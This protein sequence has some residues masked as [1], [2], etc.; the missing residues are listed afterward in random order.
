MRRILFTAL[1]ALTLVAPSVNA[2]EN[3]Q[4]A[5]ALE[6][7]SSGEGT[8]R[9]AALTS[10]LR[11]A[12]EQ[13]VGITVNSRTYV[14]NLKQIEDRVFSQSSGYIQSYEVV[15]EARTPQGA[16]RVTV[17]A[18]VTREAL[19]Q[20]LEPIVGSSI[21]F[22]GKTA[23]AN[24][25]VEQVKKVDLEK[26]LASQLNRLVTEGIKISAEPQ[27]T[28]TSGSDDTTIVLSK[29]VVVVDSDVY[30]Q[31]REFHSGFVK[32]DG[33]RDILSVMHRWINRST[34]YFVGGNSVALLDK[35]SKPILVKSPVWYNDMTVNL[36]GDI[37]KKIVSQLLMDKLPY[38]APWFERNVTISI[39]V[40][41]PIIP[42]ISRIEFI[43]GT[44]IYKSNN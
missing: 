6:V 16:Y 38:E 37:E 43:P 19:K 32:L 31:Y 10:A 4:A 15:D 3:T 23:L 33:A 21:A 39:P 13:V 22:D 9:E 24:F 12:I 36:G 35:D 8:S 30:A 29:L 2:S 5:T 1:L 44:F 20:A 26:E 25:Q 7:I 27:M 17:S 34:G 41:K 28:A 42:K 14:T 11:H 18:K 40:S